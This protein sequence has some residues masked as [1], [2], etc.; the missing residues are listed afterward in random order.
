MRGPSVA[1]GVTARVFQFAIERG[2]PRDALLDRSG[3]APSVL[4]DPDARVP[5]ARHLAVLRAA[6]A[7]SNEP[8]FALHY[9]AA[10]NLA[11]ASVVGLIGYASETML[12]AF[13]QLQRYARL[14]TDFGP[15]LMPRF[16][17]ERDVAGLWIADHRPD[18]DG[19]PELTEIAFA[20]IVGGT[21]RFGDGPFVQAVEV[22]HRD[23]GYRADY[24]RVLSAPIRFGCAR[25]RM[26]VDARWLTRRVAVQPRYAFAILTRHADVLLARLEGAGTLAAR[27]EAA[28][29]PVLHT[30]GNGIAETAARLGLGRDTLYRRLKREDT[31]FE[32]VRDV[33]RYRLALDYLGGGNVSV[34]EIAYLL[35]FGD[36]AAFSRAFKRWTGLS[37]GAYRSRSR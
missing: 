33:L 35:G 8:A 34:N 6:A 36:P 18:P 13:A 9:G 23:P 12:D 15:G 31:T 28:L 29:L 2:V 24:E 1:A 19:T 16:A 25:N 10:V 4:D 14:I 30:G 7:L 20:Q 5:L 26:R 27:V 32:H 21:R 17:L 3:V 37:P 11:E 22:T